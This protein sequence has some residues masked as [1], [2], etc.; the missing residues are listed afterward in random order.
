MKRHL[1]PRCPL[2]ERAGGMG[3]GRNF[4]RGGPIVDYFRGSQKYFSMG[5][6]SGKL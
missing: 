2:Y 3:V 5:A 1:R 4:S 6:K